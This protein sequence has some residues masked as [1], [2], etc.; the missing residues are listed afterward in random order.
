MGGPDG[1]SLAVLVVSCNPFLEGSVR[2][3]VETQGWRC[4]SIDDPPSSRAADADVVVIDLAEGTSR[5]LHDMC[6]RAPAVGIVA[7][8]ELR[9]VLPAVRSGV[10]AVVPR[11]CPPA[12][13]MRAIK[14]AS[15]GIAQIP[16]ATMRALVTQL[17]APAKPAPFDADERVW[18]RMLANGLTV[19]EVAETAG[20]STRAMF[21][22]L[23]Q[24]YRRIGARNRSEAFIIATRFGVDLLAK[25]PEMSPAVWP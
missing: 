23:A 2:L 13:L 14:A 25:R 7:S 22:L 21:R 11:D 1:D 5:Q 10:R 12:D 3:L 8:A 24:L 15:R 16:A 6:G 9:D 18:L 19:E 4:R 17:Q 20:Y